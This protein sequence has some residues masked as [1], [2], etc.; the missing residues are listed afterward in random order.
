M[1]Q[2]LPPPGRHRGL[3]KRPASRR[4]VVVAQVPGGRQ[5]QPPAWLPA[6]V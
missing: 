4:G 3:S 2:I 1:R 6:V 5:R